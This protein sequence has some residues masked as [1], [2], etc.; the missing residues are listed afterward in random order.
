MKRVIITR[1]LCLFWAGFVLAGGKVLASDLD[2]IGATLLRT[3]VTNLD[4]TGIAVLQAEAGDTTVTNWQVDPGVL[5][6]PGV[7]FT[8]SANAGS[9]NRFPNALGASSGH[10]GGVAG[11]F[12]AVASN[13]LRL[14]NCE[15]N[16]F[17]GFIVGSLAT[18]FADP[19]ANQSF[20]FGNVPAGTQQS[21]DRIYDN[22]A[23]QYNTLFISAANN[24][25]AVSPPATSYNSLGVGAYGGSSS[26]G[27]TIDNGRA[28]PDL[29]APGGS[30][31]FST[32][33]VTGAAALLLQAGLRGDGGDTNSAVDL[34]VIK[35]LLM[36]GA[37]KPAGW[38]NQFPSPLDPRYGAGVLNILNSYQQLAGGKHGFNDS[39]SV[40]INNPHPPTGA[41]GTVN[42]LSGWDFNT[43]TSSAGANGVNHYYFNVTN[44]VSGA[45]FT[46]TATLV[47]NRQRNQTGINNLDLF[48]YDAMSG[49]LVACSTSLVDNVEHLWLPRLAQG[50]YDLQVVKCG[51]STVS[52]AEPYA[53]AFEFFSLPLKVVTSGTNLVLN[54]PVYPTGFVIES[55][56]NI[57]TGAAWHSLS[58]LVVTVTNGQNYALLSV[59]NVNLTF[60]LMRP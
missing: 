40:S 10:A 9:T 12:Y 7:T 27:P 28:K 8:Y 59:T 45:P 35:A 47:W 1:M 53:L 30:T 51:G 50:R 34:R 24:G 22:Y 25:G 37:I 38:T 32:P 15:A 21:I 46:A 11:N 48:L 17:F 57:L 19:L 31:S 23:S 41:I 16:Y 33:L 44:A 58:N 36:N 49:N 54:W 26:V 55:T 2:T 6:P 39:T 13:A 52:A 18:N 14:D 42:G 5:G 56:A 20:T 29:T 4:G 43:N 60:R 3:L